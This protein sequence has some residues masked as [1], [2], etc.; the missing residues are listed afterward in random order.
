[1]RKISSIFVVAIMTI[2]MIS[3][4]NS[5]KEKAQ[6]SVDDYAMY[7]DSVSNTMA[8]DA[9][10]RWD[11]IE[12]YADKKREQAQNELRTLEDKADLDTKMEASSKKF[13]EF[14]QSVVDYRQR[15][16]AEN[17]KIAMRSSLFKGVVIKE[18]M[19][20]D[21]VNK[22][23]ILSVYDHFVTTATK[24]KDS[25]TREQ[26][27]DIKMMYEGLDTRK[28]TVEKEGLT[29]ADNLKIAGLKIQF[30]TMYKINRIGAK[31]EENQ[32]AKE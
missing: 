6:T 15:K 11:E 4:K 24:N 27:D 1:M 21:W 7:I 3:C 16:E 25:Y 12:K 17:A 32:E 30:A 13:D 5:D 2:A 22:D 18:D 8:N 23:N 14:R 10:Q 20:F 19:S 9:E 26:W 31:A 29:S 28:N